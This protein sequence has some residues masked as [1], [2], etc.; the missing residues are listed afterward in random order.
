MRQVY[1]FE[2]GLYSDGSG[3]RG[4]DKVKSSWK[5]CWLRRLKDQA[6][7]KWFHGGDYLRFSF[8][9]RMRLWIFWPASFRRGLPSDAETP[10]LSSVLPLADMASVCLL[11]RHPDLSRRRFWAGT[12][13]VGRVLEPRLGGAHIRALTIWA[14][15]DRPKPGSFRRSQTRFGLPI[16]WPPLFCR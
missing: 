2:S 8:A 3:F 12:D 13:L 16:V 11:L 14:F 15:P 4:R 1:S 10:D 6:S 7:Q 9:R 5:A